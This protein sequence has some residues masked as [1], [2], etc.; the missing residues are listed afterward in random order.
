M[1]S[2][3]ERVHKVV[4]EQLGVELVDVLNTSR[5]VDDLRADSLDIV[6]LVMGLE[7]E[8]GLVIPDEEAQ[9]I[10]TV[11]A[12]IVYITQRTQ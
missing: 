12:A 11:G 8:F 10:S 2:I 7:E 3:Q 5:F 6:E 9:K 1:A 4:A